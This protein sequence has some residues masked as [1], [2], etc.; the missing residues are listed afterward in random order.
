MRTRGRSYI[1]YDDWNGTIVCTLI[2]TKPPHTT[3]RVPQ[4]SLLY[5]TL[6]STEHHNTY[7][8]GHF[9]IIIHDDDI[10]ENGQLFV[11][12]L[13]NVVFKHT[14]C[15]NNNHAILLFADESCIY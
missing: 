13:K 1:L 8:W 15:N 7:S 9:H 3:T 4:S 12:N 10:R 5:S 2:L 14:K 6:P 11:S